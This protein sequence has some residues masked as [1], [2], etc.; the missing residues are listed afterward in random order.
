MS[1]PTDRPGAGLEPTTAYF[2]AQ[3]SAYM[4]VDRSRLR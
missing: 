4:S 1:I 2:V 3:E